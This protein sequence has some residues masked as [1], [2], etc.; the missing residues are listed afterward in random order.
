MSRQGQKP[1]RSQLHGPGRR[2]LERV[3]QRVMD[4]ILDADSPLTSARR[5]RRQLHRYRKEP[6]LFGFDP[7]K[8][9]RCA[10]AAGWSAYKAGDRDTCLKWWRGG[11]KLQ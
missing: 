4:H 11:G 3:R 5:S 10:G 1:E 8:L 6:H 2:H 9:S 7:R